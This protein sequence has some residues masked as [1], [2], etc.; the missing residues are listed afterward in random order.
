MG[1]QCLARSARDRD[2]LDLGRG[3]KAARDP[4]QLD[5]LRAASLPP[6]GLDPRTAPQGLIKAA[7]L[8]NAAAHGS[9]RLMDLARSGDDARVA[10]L[11]QLLS[12]WR[13]PFCR[14]P[15]RAAEPRLS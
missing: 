2:R 11:H 3:G 12:A 5:G 1:G 7:R 6:C 14:R 13:G 9:A 10:A 8:W 4:A 15:Q